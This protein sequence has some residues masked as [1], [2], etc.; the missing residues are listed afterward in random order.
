MEITKL[1]APDSGASGVTPD[2]GPAEQGAKA[3]PNLIATADRLDI[4][5]LDVSA[6]LQILIAEVR[7]SLE[8]QTLPAADTGIFAPAAAVDNPLQAA[9]AL[10]EI[11]LQAQPE[12]AGI[13]QWDTAL[14]RMEMQLHTGLERAVDT[15]ASWRD[16][17]APVVQT[18]NQT[19]AL[20]LALLDEGPQN[21]LW[22]RPEWAGLAPRFDRFWRRRRRAR[23]GL[24]DPDTSRGF[25]NHEHQP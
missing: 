10:V 8:S 21:P 20:V 3:P 24:T 6:A 22:L 11:I 5:P 14:T 17:S 9:L 4:R 19:R 18:V 16:I 25:D 23:R 1:P 15:V 2:V 12:E 13:E 7:A